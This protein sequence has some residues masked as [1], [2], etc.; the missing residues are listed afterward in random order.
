MKASLN[1]QEKRSE[2]REKSTK[3]KYLTSSLQCLSNDDVLLSL[4]SMLQ[5]SKNGT[6]GNYTAKGLREVQ[7]HPMYGYGYL[8][9]EEA[10]HLYSSFN[11]LSCPDK[12][13]FRDKLLDPDYGLPVYVNTEPIS[14][15][16]FV[17]LKN[18]SGMVKFLVDYTTVLTSDTSYE[19]EGHVIDNTLT[20][21]LK[22][23]DTEYD[24]NVPRSVILSFPQTTGSRID[25]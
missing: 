9:H 25:H 3:G 19:R 11:E 13:A 22:S 5:R 18:G 23:M 7:Q 8:D 12:Q 1:W 4:E 20:I 21:L 14:C 24:R 16:V 17:V 2:V 15:K 6:M 10:Y